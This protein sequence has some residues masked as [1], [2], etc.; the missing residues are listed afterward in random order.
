MSHMQYYFPVDQCVLEFP[1]H[2]KIHTTTTIRNVHGEGLYS[3]AAAA[4]VVKVWAIYAYTGKGEVSKDAHISR[5][6]REI[7]FMLHTTSK[8]KE[9]LAHVYL[10]ISSERASRLDMHSAAVIC[11]SELPTH[12]LSFSPAA[13]V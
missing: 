7:S 4:A 1:R 6:P 13:R 3:E 8:I 10:Y 11:N 9:K 2:I 5:K 12:L